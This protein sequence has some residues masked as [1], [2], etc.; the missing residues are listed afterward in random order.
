MFAAAIALG[1]VA[2]W[3]I[4]TSTTQKRIELGIL[5]GLWGL[6]LGAFSMFGSRRSACGGRAAPGRPRRRRRAVRRRGRAGPLNAEVERMEETLER[7][8][9]EARLEQMLRR[10]IQDAM[11]REVSALRAEIAPLRGELLEKVGGQLRLER[12]ET[13]RV[14]GS[15]LEALQHEVRQLKDARTPSSAPT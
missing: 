6:L 14:I 8:A 13:T 9:C 1:A 5:A 15:D 7:R 4:V 3:L 2:V 12:I 11:G 10:E